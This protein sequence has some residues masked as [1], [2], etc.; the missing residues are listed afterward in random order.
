MDA[1]VSAADPPGYSSILNFRQWTDTVRL[2]FARQQLHEVAVFVGGPSE[3][4]AIVFVHYIQSTRYLNNVGVTLFVRRL[5][6]EVDGSL[7]IPLRSLDICTA[8]PGKRCEGDW[9]VGSERI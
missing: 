1:R 4:W 3:E 7:A 8:W 2:P 5:D 6:G 9:N